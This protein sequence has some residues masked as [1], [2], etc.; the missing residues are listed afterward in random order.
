LR[1]G[2]DGS[3]ELLFYLI[4]IVPVLICDEVD[5]NSKV[6]V[7]ARSSD[8]VEVSLGVLGEVEVYYHVDRADV[9]TT[10]KQIW[11]GK[12]IGKY[13]WLVV[14]KLLKLNKNGI[15][16]ENKTIKHNWGVSFLHGTA[17]RLRDNK[18]KSRT[19]PIHLK[20]L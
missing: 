19:L 14:K 7:S 5:C 15:G 1:D 9:Y 18:F 17:G 20:Q 2:T 3:A 10:S 11:R 16:S 12:K 4:Q 6:T 8:T 13:K